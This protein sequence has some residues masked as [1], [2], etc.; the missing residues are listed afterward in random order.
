MFENFRVFCTSHLVILV[1][2]VLGVLLIW[3]I[4]PRLSLNIQ[5]LTKR[6]LLFGLSL[7][8]VIFNIWHLYFGTY[9]ITR[10]L[11]LHLCTISVILLI[12]TLIFDNKFVNKLVLFWSPVSAFLAIA[13]PDMNASENFPSFRFLEFFSSHVLIIWSV[14]FIFRVQ[15]TVVIFK[16]F[17]ISVATLMV[18]LPFVY[19]LNISIGSNYMY[20]NHKPNGGQMHFLPSEPWHVLGAMIL[21]ILVFFLEYLVYRF[22]VRI[23]IKTDEQVSNLYN[24]G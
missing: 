6:L 12:F 13:L 24:F 8:F 5:K 1:A 15:K 7:Q 19:W 10:F 21:V 14:I 23:G 16:D 11:P 17:I 22:T 18:T 4:L 2:L 9:D 3:F 20:L